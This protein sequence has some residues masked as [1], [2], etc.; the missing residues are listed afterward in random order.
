MVRKLKWHKQCLDKASTVGSNPIRTT[1]IMGSLIQVF[2][3][4]MQVLVPVALV[5]IL[6]AALI[7]I[8]I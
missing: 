7:N 2:N 6:V 3:E 1:K 5:L 4:L 8:F